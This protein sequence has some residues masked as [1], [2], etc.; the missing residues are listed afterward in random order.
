[1]CKGCIE[2]ILG[3]METHSI[4]HDSECM[5]C[6]VP[7]RQQRASLSGVV[8]FNVPQPDSADFNDRLA[9]APNTGLSLVESWQSDLHTDPLLEDCRLY[10]WP[11]PSKA[12]TQTLQKYYLVSL[13]L[14]DS[15]HFT[16]KIHLLSIQ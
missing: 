6:E 14:E 5:L 7:G 9:A 8:R 15:L 2:M 10:G 12:D 11:W 1:M 13:Q 3:G 4:N 16:S